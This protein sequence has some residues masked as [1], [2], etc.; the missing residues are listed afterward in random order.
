MCL[1][2][3]WCHYVNIIHPTLSLLRVSFV[4]RGIGIGV[5]MRN[6]HAK[7]EYFALKFMFISFTWLFIIMLNIICVFMC[8]NN[9]L[10]YSWF[11]AETD[12]SH[13]VFVFGDLLL[14]LN[15]FSHL[16]VMRCFETTHTLIIVCIYGIQHTQATEDNY[17]NW[18]EITRHKCIFSRTKNVCRLKITVIVDDSP[19]RSVF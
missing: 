17:R 13:K 11:T 4:C 7:N 8:T 14:L 19:I 18:W 2:N 16:R 6:I 15:Y 12:S 9:E 5:R 3:H 10:D 1:L